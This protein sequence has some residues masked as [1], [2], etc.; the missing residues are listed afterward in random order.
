MHGMARQPHLRLP[1]PAREASVAAP[2]S[3]SRLL[4]RSVAFFFTGLGCSFGS[5]GGGS[6]IF[7][8]ASF[9]C[10]GQ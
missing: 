7:M 4:C 5:S 3:F 9:G 2:P 1:G 6:G 10:R 8:S